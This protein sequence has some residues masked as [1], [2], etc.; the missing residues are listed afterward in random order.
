MTI[1]NSCL[2]LLLVSLFLFPVH[3]MSQQTQLTIHDLIPGGKTYPD[4]VP[5]T[6]KQLKWCG[7]EYIYVEGNDLLSARPGKPA[8][9]ILSLSELNDRLGKEKEDIRLSGMPVFSVPYEKEPVLSFVE[10]GERFHYDLKQ[11]A[12]VARYTLPKEGKNYEFSSGSSFIAFTEGN[13]IRILSPDNRMIE[14][15]QDTAKHVVYGQAVHQREFGIYK[16]LFWSPSGKKLA[17]Y[18]MDESMVTDYPIVNIDTRIA[19][20]EPYKYPMAGMKSHEVTVGI[21]DVA[22]GETVWLK[23]GEPKEKYLTNI[24]WSLDEKSLYIAELNRDQNECRLIRYDVATGEKELQ[25]FTESKNTYV[26]PQHPVQFVPGHPDTFIWQSERDGFNH[27]YLYDTTGKLLKQLTTGSWV[28][29]DV[30]GFDPKGETLFYRSTAAHP[31]DLSGNRTALE[32]HTWKVNLKTGKQE[33]VTPKPGVHQLLLSPDRTYAL[34]IFSSP[35]VPREI[36]LIDLKTKKTVALLQAE[37]PF[38]NYTLPE[39]EVGQ[40]KAADGVTDLNYRLVKP[41]RLDAGKKYPVIIYVYG[42]PHSQ[43]INGSWQY[44]TRG[45]DLYMAQQD[46]IVFTVDGRGSANR[47]HAFESAIFRHLGVNEMADQIQGGRVSEDASL[48]GSGAYRG[49]WLELRRFYDYQSDAYL[50]GSL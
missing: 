3:M 46:V 50:S 31:D 16:G 23:T 27:I 48:C 21:Y 42:G 41:A 14:V 34:D 11:G 2:T 7:E 8:Q 39:I 30:L 9:V 17:F 32:N 37:D 40:L 35:A 25:L 49:T 47:G 12:I 26:E 45:W 22:S 1:K 19:Q 24:A 20:A 18:R 44:G 15:T 10:K 43:L 13:N 29:T 6:L 5:A 28:V 33:C 38:K 4:F 36:D